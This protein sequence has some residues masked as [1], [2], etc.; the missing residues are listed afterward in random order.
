MTCREVSDGNGACSAAAVFSVVM[1]DWVTVRGNTAATSFVQAESGWLRLA[2]FRDLTAWVHATQM[3]PTSVATINLETSPTDDP[4]LFQSLLSFDV[5]AGGVLVKSARAN[6]VTVPLASVLRW[7]VIK[8]TSSSDWAVTFRVIVS[9]NAVVPS[10]GL[11]LDGDDYGT[12]QPAIAP[13]PAPRPR[14]PNDRPVSPHPRAPNDRPTTAFT[15]TEAM[16]TAL[17]LARSG[18][19]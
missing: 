13:A 6:Q 7:S 8:Q 1:Q 10:F 9:L 18:G 15:S 4:S 2:G 12:A 19:R 3:S 14:A 5:G 16:R 17:A 11:S